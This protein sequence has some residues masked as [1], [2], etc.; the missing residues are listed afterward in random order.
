MRLKISDIAD[1]TGISPS[2]IR[3]YEKEGIIS[4]KRSEN[5]NYREYGMHEV[6]ILCGCRW[7]RSNGYSLEETLQLMK[8]ADSKEIAAAMEHQCQQI[9]QEIVKKKL[10]IKVLHGRA[11]D[12]IM[13]LPQKRICQIVSNPVI[14][15]FK[16]S[17]P[18]RKQELGGDIPQMFNSP[19]IA[20]FIDSSLLFHES[21]I[22]SGQGDLES[23]WGVSIDEEN[24]RTL[25]FSPKAP[26][27]Y[28]ASQK[29]IKT[30]VEIADDL[31][32]PSDQLNQAREFIDEHHLEI[33]GPAV[34]QRLIN[35][36]VAGENHRYDRLWIPVK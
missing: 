7:F 23:D 6:S 16:L 2:G 8:N 9:E 18:N 29:C 21:E 33:T 36:K 20:P 19:I 32:L 26:A 11:D 30:I 35:E 25:R 17:K 4:P 13:V 12:L 5:G 31:T 24:A 3:F 1:M 28:F 22:C 15:W 14:L 27:Q 34:S 10:L